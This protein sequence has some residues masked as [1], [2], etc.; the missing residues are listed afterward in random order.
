MKSKAASKPI[1]LR[2]KKLLTTNQLRQYLGKLQIN[3][4]GSLTEKI[5]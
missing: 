3:N 1:P 5:F 4:I 2:K